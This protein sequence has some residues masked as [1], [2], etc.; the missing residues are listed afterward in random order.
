MDHTLFIERAYINGKFVRSAHAFEVVNPATGKS[1]GHMPDMTTADTK[2]AIIAADK[3]WKAWDNLPIG[4]RCAF[5]RKLYELILKHKDTLAKIMTLESGKPLS[6]SLAEV[7]YGSSFV[8]WF[9][10]EGKRVYGETIPTLKSGVHL[11][12][13]K[14]SVGVV[15][16]ITPWNFPL[17]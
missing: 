3:A 13:I 4:E 14:Q 17:A 5:V 16:A 7:D 6:E 9:A 12:T 10:E 11:A 8:E 2:K 1:V 15:A